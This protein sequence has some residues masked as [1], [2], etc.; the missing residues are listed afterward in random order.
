M[1][2]K[3]EEN[4]LFTFQ[5]FL[6]LLLDA[7]KTIESETLVKERKNF[8]SYQSHIYE[9]KDSCIP[10]LSIPSAALKNQLLNFLQN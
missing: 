4:I 3:E 10:K 7:V 2:I 8:L 5:S 6:N 1:V 9:K